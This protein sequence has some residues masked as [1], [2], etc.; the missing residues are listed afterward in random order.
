MSLGL[1]AGGALAEGVRLSLRGRVK[2]QCDA[3]QQQQ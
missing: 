1:R 2:V 3:P